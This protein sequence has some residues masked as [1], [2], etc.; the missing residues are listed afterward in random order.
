MYMP[1]WLGLSIVVLREVWYRE[2]LDA[3]APPTAAERFRERYP[4][5][6]YRFD[7]AK[8][9]I[10]LGALMLVIVV[11]LMLRAASARFYGL[12][13]LV[14]MVGIGAFIAWVVDV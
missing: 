2:P 13:G 6:G 11:V 1:I 4:S 5:L 10:A 8:V 9:A 7:G 3:D 12:V 14:A